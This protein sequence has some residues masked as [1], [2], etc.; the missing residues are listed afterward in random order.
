MICN[1]I[2][3]LMLAALIQRHDKNHV[4]PMYTTVELIVVTVTFSGRPRTGIGCVLMVTIVRG[5]FPS[6]WNAATEN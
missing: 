5:P 3:E 6:S 1:R 4:M 2:S